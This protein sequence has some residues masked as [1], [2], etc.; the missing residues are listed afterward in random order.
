MI[1]T[2]SSSEPQLKLLRISGWTS[3]M[4]ELSA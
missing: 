1:A 4:G 2:S 3:P